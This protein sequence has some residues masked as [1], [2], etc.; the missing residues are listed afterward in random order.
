MGS[1]KQARTAAI[2]TSQ[3]SWQRARRPEQKQQRQSAIIAAAR[4]LVDEGGVDNATLSAIAKSAGISKANCYRYY[5]S[6]EAILLDVFLQEA[7][8]HTQCI[9]QALTAYIGSN[10]VNATATVIV[11]NTVERPRLLNL[12]SALWSVLERNISEE[13]ITDFKR[14]FH[15]L[16]AQ[17]AR[18]I[19]Q[20]HP[21]LSQQQAEVFAS[22]YLLFI[23]SA[24]QAANPPPAVAAVMQRAEFCGSRI[25]FQPILHAHTLALLKGMLAEQ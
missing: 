7:K 22:C 10:D 11:Q 24:W 12:V 1:D 18:I 2:S 3:D 9:V 6:R 17:W 16:S 8:D 19:N 21:Q 20:V 14:Q 4:K 15:T 23:A 13:L 25:E 5:E